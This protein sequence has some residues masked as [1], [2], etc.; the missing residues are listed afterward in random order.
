MG[1]FSDL[2]GAVR[3]R[4]GLGGA[5]RPDPVPPGQP[6]SIEA[7][8]D[9]MR[10]IDAGLATGDGVRAF[11]EMYL[12]VTELVRDRITAGYFTDTAAMTRL[13]LV[14][15]GLYLDAVASP[16]PA[17]AWA[18]LFEARRRQGVLSIQFALAGMNAHINHD[19]P[20]AVV[21][22]CRQLGTT[23]DA[24]G[25]VDDYQRVTGLL[26]SVQ[27][28]VRQSFFDGL[29]LEVDREYAAPLANLLSSWS[30]ARAR[31]A[32]WT[33]AGVLW[34]LQ[35][36]EPLRSDFLA[37]LSKSVGMAGRYLLTPVADL[38]R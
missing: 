20:L 36:V 9:R 16:A 22:T 33:N 5:G 26:E 11:G 4:L 14:F 27:E 2:V 15:A 28:R 24:P 38:A 18:P 25:F 35:G 1:W 31:D 37:T 3:T 17:N 12:Q 34:R 7:V 13:D 32:A 23:P 6:T 29:A 19:L 8:V 21:T 30:I 10:T